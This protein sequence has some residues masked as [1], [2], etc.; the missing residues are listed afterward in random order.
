[1]QGRRFALRQLVS[2]AAFL[3]FAGKA[4][5]RDPVVYAYDALGRLTSAAYPG[6]VTI[7]YAYDAAGNRTLVA[8]G[9]PPPP[10]P[11]TASLSAS[12]WYSGPGGVDPAVVVTATGGTPPYTYAWQRVSGNP[13]TQAD[14]PTAS[15]T[16][17]TFT[18]SGTMPPNKVSTWRCQVTD[19]ASTTVHTANATVTINVL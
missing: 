3:A 6:G 15:T 7:N 16:T 10:P 1:M 14:A 5:A 2:V 4:Q 19:A 17:W 12:T 8:T 13:N 18:G 9:A 11:I